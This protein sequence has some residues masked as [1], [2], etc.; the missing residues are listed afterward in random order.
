MMVR[1]WPEKSP[2]RTPTIIPDTRDSI[3]AIL[4]YTKKL[5]WYTTKITKYY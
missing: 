1:G 4:F 5:S 2:Y 3:D